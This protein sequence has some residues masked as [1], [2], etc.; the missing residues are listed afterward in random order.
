MMTSEKAKVVAMAYFDALG[1]LQCAR[2]FTKSSLTDS[3]SVL[4]IIFR[5]LAFA[6]NTKTIIVHI[7]VNVFLLQTRKLKRSSDQIF[8]RVLM[9]IHA[10]K[11]EQQRIE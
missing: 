5:H 6:R 11:N 2:K 1:Q 3:P 7:D 9:E 10:F 8:S 4:V